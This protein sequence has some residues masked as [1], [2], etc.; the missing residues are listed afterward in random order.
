MKGDPILVVENEENI[1]ALLQEVLLAEGYDCDA[2]V[3]G[4][5]A[6]EKLRCRE[7]HLVL[8]DILMPVKSGMDLLKETR[9]LRP[10]RPL[11]W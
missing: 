6:L 8:T 10:I 5:N 11:S 3:N 1:R 4:A 9:I 2:A 7:Y